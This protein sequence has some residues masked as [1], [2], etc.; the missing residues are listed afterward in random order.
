MKATC[1]VNITLGWRDANADQSIRCGRHLGRKGGH[2]IVGEDK[3]VV[4][5]KL[6]RK[7]KRRSL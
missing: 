3:V 7:Q 6:F 2:N 4:R 5:K 1:K